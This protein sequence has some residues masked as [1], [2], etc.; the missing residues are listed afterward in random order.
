MTNR[1]TIILL[2]S[3]LCVGEDQHPFTNA[4]IYKIID[5]LKEKDLELKDLSSMNFDKI[6]N[7]FYD[8]KNLSEEEI[9]F[10]NRII[11]LLKRQGS[12]IFD[13]RDLNDKGIKLLTIF[14]D[15]YPKIFLD[16]LNGKAPVIL[17]YLGNLDLL[18]KKFIGFS[19][20]RIKK[21]NENDEKITNM[22]SKAAYDNGF[23]TITGGASGIDTYATQESIRNNNY[24]I[25]FVS[26][27][28]AN[29]AKI[30]KIAQA[31]QNNN[32]LLLSETQ[33]FASFNVGMAMARNKYIYLLSH[34]T[35]VV[36]AQYTI[37][38]KKKT[39]GTWNGAIENMKT[40]YANVCVIENNKVNG[41]K[42]LKEMGIPTITTP[43]DKLSFDI[44]FGDDYHLENNVSLPQEI[45]DK[46]L[47][48]LKD[49]HTIDEI[50]FTKKEQEN[51]D[52]IKYAIS[53]VSSNLTELNTGTA[54]TNKKIIKYVTQK[55]ESNLK[56][57]GQQLSIFDV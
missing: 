43:D 14:D 12:M 28:L 48:I 38:N 17:Y 49:E 18:N 24:F 4:Q 52:K 34:R 27:S 23:G 7:I 1:D 41:N 19:G 2:C 26:D 56:N 51:I 44:V 39:G 33:P 45:V 22:W 21:A 29:R 55:Y 32:C 53:K 30:V 54:S 16:K 35:I 36:K 11:S 46:L 10:I 37:K 9:A 6:K 40:N 3:T 8:D 5:K 15:K 57:K 31:L 50:K 13:M 25:E 42:E 20:S 47:Q